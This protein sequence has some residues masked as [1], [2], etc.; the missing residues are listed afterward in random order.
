MTRSLMITGWMLLL[1][2][3][4]LPAAA[5]SAETGVQTVTQGWSFHWDD[6][7][8]VSPDGSDVDNQHSAKPGSGWQFANADWQPLASLDDLPPR[9]EHRIVWLR[10]TLPANTWRNPHLLINSMDLTAQVFEN[11]ELTYAVGKIDAQGNSEF[12]GW[13]W[14]LVPVHTLAA[15][16]TLYFRVFSDYASYIGP[17]GTVSVGEKS[18]LLDQIYRRGLAGF[19]FIVAI[20]ISG[21]LVS[22]LGIIQREW[23]IALSTGL[24]SLD[25][26][27]MMFA[28][29]ELSQLILFTPLQWRAIAAF[30][31]FMVPMLLA[32]LV[33]EWL[34]PVIIRTTTL[35]FWLSA[36]FVVSV[37]LLSLITDFRFIDAYPIF[38]I[39]F[40]VLVLGIFV[41]C[42]YGFKSLSTED[43]LLLFGILTLF[44]SLLMDM[45]SAHELIKWIARS[46]QW[47]LIFFTLSMLIIY[48]I[49]NW[50]QQQH[51]SQLMDTLETQVVERTR[52]L[53]ESHRQLEQMAT[54]DFLT[55]LMNRRAFMELAHVELANAIRHQYPFSL[56]LLD[57]DHFK[58]VNDTYGHAEGDQVLQALAKVAEKESRQGDLVCRYGGEEFVILL[59]KTGEQDARTFV[60]RLHKAIGEI[61]IPI[62]SGNQQL[63]VTASMGLVVFS[64]HL[65]AD[66]DLN[67]LSS[68]A[69]ILEF[70]LR[71]ADEAMY[72]A[73]H[74]GRN[75]IKTRLFSASALKLS[76]Q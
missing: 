5:M 10:L 41:G 7:D 58:Q 66:V 61:R 17:S 31:Y 63:S 56:L 48:L 18:D 26:V 20:L 47:G 49:K 68:P 59:P 38:D 22:C 45:L 1:T 25:L 33:R 55:G 62:C 53:T 6:I 71:E 16:T 24:L 74:N 42:F 36:L 28:E 40:I 75:N 57:I 60:Q 70:T 51:L 32:W 50:N 29:N 4:S 76:W 15:P 65:A 2:L 9:G 30:S 8:F 35:I 11:G 43:K 3:L 54:R 34:K 13:P 67:R 37:A 46:G 12:V 64:Q 69:K 21:L 19:T 27:I 23:R 14:L 52:E 44:A 72:D 39:L 73:K